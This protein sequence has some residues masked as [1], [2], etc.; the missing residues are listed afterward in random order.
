MTEQAQQPE[1]Q[2]TFI[3][4][5]L[6]MAVQQGL[7][8]WGLHTLTDPAL[9]PVR[10]EA[11]HLTLAFL[12]AS[13]PE[14]VKRLTA[15]IE[16]LAVEPV[17]LAFK[18]QPAARPRRMPRF[19]AVEVDSEGV[20]RL[21]ARLQADLVASGLADP[22]EG[23]FW[24]HV[25][26]ARVRSRSGASGKPRRVLSTPEALPAALLEPFDGVRVSLYRSDLMPRGAEYVP[27]ARKDLPPTA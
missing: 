3:A 8:A 22:Y 24:P 12:G 9:R 6:P 16:A 14:Q 23:R 4:L 19:I 21:W 26:V 11:L 18:P 27:L 25:T 17:A 13:D 20:E 7:A 5:D 1:M 2:R 15:V 10:P